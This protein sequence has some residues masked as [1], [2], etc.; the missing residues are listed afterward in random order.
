MTSPEW[1]EPE[2]DLSSL[3]VVPADAPE[4]V[5]PNHRATADPST[6]EPE[7]KSVRDRLMGT[8]TK[9][10]PRNVKVPKPRKV[11]PNRP[12][13]FIEPLETF[14]NTMAMVL[15][16]FKP[17]VSM[18]IMSPAGPST[19]DGVEPPTV[20]RNCAV[21]WDEAAQRSEVVRNFLDS[22]T[23]ISVAGKLLA[24]HAPIALAL[25]PPRFSPAQAM[26]D[27]LKRRAQEQE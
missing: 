9:T 22:F 16:P 10:E 26:E 5:V 6:V 14:Y 21:A 27:M 8:K 15:M 1:T 24:A 20:A 4:F 18:V 23:T 25:M 19:E 11:V 2:L 12:G 13:Q 7:R 3:N 17:E